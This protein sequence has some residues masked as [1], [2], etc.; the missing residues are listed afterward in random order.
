MTLLQQQ[1][2]PEKDLLSSDKLT[3][4]EIKLGV[5][6]LLSRGFIIKEVKHKNFYYE[7][8]KLDQVEKE[9]A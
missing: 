5:H 8:R 2:L 6:Y 7:I 1:P 4:K 3:E 9:V